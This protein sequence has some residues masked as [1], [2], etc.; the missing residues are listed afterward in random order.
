MRPAEVVRRGAD[1]LERH[2]VG[3]PEANAEHLML[4]I[5]GIDRAELVRRRDGLT[6]AEARAYGRALCR[7][8]TG[9]PLQH[10][11]GEQAFRHLVLT[12]RPGVFIP[13]P[14]T[15]VV[16]DV[17]LAAIDG[18]AAPSVVD[19]GTGTGA[20]G[21]SIAQEHP[22]ARVWATD[23]SH[24]AVA[25]ARENAERLGLDV[26]VLE[27]ELLEPLPAELRGSLDLVVANPPYVPPDRAPDLS[28]EVL[29]D[30]ADALFAGP[31]LSGRIL[32]IAAVWL[33]PEGH[34]VLEIDDEA[35]D[36]VSGLAHRSGF[37]DVV[38]HEDLAGRPRVVAG[39]R[40]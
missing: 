29:A 11:T 34:V 4:S 15:E 10:L 35:A 19:V 5:L 37:A 33:R 32:D 24:E 27:G 12:V 1:Y 25:L 14:E 3:S 18:G 2:G 17:A 30:P 22:G 28:P 39:R 6:M 21:L 20:I 40:P 31:E 16:V 38:V 26:T 23:R 8:C 9:T 36:A 13:R 7:R